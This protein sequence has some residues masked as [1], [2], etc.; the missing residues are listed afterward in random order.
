MNDLTVD[1]TVH[2]EILDIT[3]FDGEGQEYIAGKFRQPSIDSLFCSEHGYVF[4]GGL[5]SEGINRVVEE[6]LKENK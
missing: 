1:A 2:G 4:E 3:A 6:H 5:P